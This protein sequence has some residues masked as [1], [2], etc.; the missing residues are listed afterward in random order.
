M[1]FIP[2]PKLGW[3]RILGTIFFYDIFFALVDGLSQ[4]PC[5]CKA[6][7]ISESWAASSPSSRRAGLVS[8][9]PK[10][11]LYTLYDIL[12]P[13]FQADP[14]V[15]IIVH[16]PLRGGRNLIGRA[17]LTKHTCMNL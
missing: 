16:V 6:L 8:S 3:Q 4:V 2:T 12:V 17:P 1:P 9:K 5:C 13:A 15:S 11:C 10:G 14:R 7:A